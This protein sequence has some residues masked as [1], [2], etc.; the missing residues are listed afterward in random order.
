[1]QTVRVKFDHG[2]GDCVYFAHQIPLYARRGWEVIVS[3]DRDKE[4]LFHAAGAKV[5][6]E[7]DVGT[8][9]V[10]WFEGYEPNGDLRADNYWIW[11]KLAR[12]LSLEPMPDVGHP[13]ALW[14]EYCRVVLHARPFLAA[15]VISSI[16]RRIA[17]LPRPL[18][19]LHT[20]GTS[21]RDRKN[22]PLD[23][24]RQ[25]CHE[26]LSC[27]GATVLLLDWEGNV[28]AIPHWRVRHMLPALGRLNTAELLAL[29]DTADLIMGIDSGPLHAARFSSTPA[30]GIWMG[31]GSPATWGLPRWQQ[32]NIVVGRDS[33]VWTRYAR[34]PFNILEC[35]E[36][37]ALPQT[38]ARTAR[39]ILE[40]PRYLRPE[41]LG[42]DVLLQQ[43]V[44]DWQGGSGNVFGG[45]NDRDQGFDRLL[46]IAAQ[47]F[48]RP[49]VVETGCVRAD[50]DFRG[51]GF[52]TLVLGLFAAS[53][54]GELVSVDHNPNHC[55]FARHMVS[56]LQPA[57]KVVESDS[58]DW[59]ANNSNP[60]D[61]LYLDSRDTDQPGC[62][63][64]ALEE[65]QAAGQSLHARSIIAFDDTCYDNGTFVGAGSLG[66]PWLMQRDWHILHSGHQT[67]LT[68]DSV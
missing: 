54:D 44:M 68:R 65:I 20:H 38:L 48:E 2:L 66:V 27:T 64:H 30:I 62:A 17:Q 18:L 34:I 49:R 67:I 8:T 9:R 16:A 29:I 51:A 7:P 10:P 37:E 53:H 5:A 3:C 15:S 40:G 26:L 6:A 35:D 4:L 31:N 43:F 39:R 42:R 13:A 21:D 60:I 11:S 56:G 14:D 59:L 32:V 57:V 33:R 58:I 22:V 36:T 47:R 52:S 12:N 41:H 28:A 55:E 1:V 61:V 23:L 25:I 45:F 63:E 24:V 50:E 19:L 46:N